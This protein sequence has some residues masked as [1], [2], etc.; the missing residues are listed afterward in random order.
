M[1]VEKSQGAFG[2]GRKALPEEIAA[3]DIDIRPDGTGFRKVAAPWPGEPI[4]TDNCAV[5]HGDFGEGAGRW[6]VLAGG[7]DT[8]RMIVRK[9]RS[10]PT[11]PICRR[12]STMSAGPCRSA[13]PGPCLTMMSMR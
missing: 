9:R 10:G 3:W 7:Q 5:C 4:Y 2:L 8:L 12:S 13:M 6:P 11:G 1:V